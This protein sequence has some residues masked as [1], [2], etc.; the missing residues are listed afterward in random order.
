MGSLIAHLRPIGGASGVGAASC[1]GWRRGSGGTAAAAR[2]PAQKQARLGH[3]AWAEAHVWA[4]E[5][6]R[7]TGL[8]RV[9]AEQ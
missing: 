9:Q 7:V 1:D 5:E 6:L 8:S 2:V 4:R 3:R